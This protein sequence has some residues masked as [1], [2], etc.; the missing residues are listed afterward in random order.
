M[1]GAFTYIIINLWSKLPLI[2]TLTLSWVGLRVEKL[3]NTAS[4]SMCYGIRT[5]LDILERG[6]I[7][8]TAKVLTGFV[9]T[10]SSRLTVR[11]YSLS[12]GVNLW[13]WGTSHSPGNIRKYAKDVFSGYICAWAVTTTGIHLKDMFYLLNNLWGQI[14]GCNFI[15]STKG[16]LW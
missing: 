15:E 8:R 3:K 1:E 16:S 9:K 10:I 2:L 13:T 4:N 7:W 14:Y 6:L 12:S 5:Y 11:L